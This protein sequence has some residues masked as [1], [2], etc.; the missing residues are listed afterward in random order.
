MARLLQAVIEKFG[1]GPVGLDTL[2]AATGEEAGTL[3]DVYEP[4]LIVRG[5]VRGDRALLLIEGET[6]YSKVKT[7]AQMVREKGTWRLVSEV[8]QIRMEE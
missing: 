4:Y 8:L 5:F 7:E 1:G 6:S 3:E 2:S